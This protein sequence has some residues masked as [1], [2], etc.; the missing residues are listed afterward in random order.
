MTDNTSETPTPGEIRADKIHAISYITD[1]IKQCERHLAG[2]EVDSLTELHEVEEA[3]D[4]VMAQSVH[5]KEQLNSFDEV[6]ASVNE[7]AAKYE[8]VRTD[9]EKS[10]AHAQSSVGQL[11]DSSNAVKENF[12]DMQE[13]FENFKNAVDEISGYMKEI[14]GI[15]SQ[16]NLLALNASIEAARAGEAGKGFA[17]VAEEVGKLSGEIGE[18]IKEVD[19]SIATAGEQSEKLSQSIGRSITALDKSLEN[20]DATY[21]TF[22]EIQKSADGSVTVQ[23]EIREASSTASD[24]LSGIENY[25]D[26]MHDNYDTLLSHIKKA[27]ELGTTK[28]GAFENINNLLLQIMP[29]LQN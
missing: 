21:A 6:F 15:A 23:D 20:V 5:L 28:S 9:I 29:I 26:S 17:V 22:D 11:K 19:A 8:T 24:E 3:F 1:A 12:S 27:N 16:T 18:L 10:I 25:F 14:V 2:N 4:D 7:S 13:I